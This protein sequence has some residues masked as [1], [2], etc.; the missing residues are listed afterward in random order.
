MLSLAGGLCCRGNSPVIQDRHHILMFS[1]YHQHMRTHTH[2]CVHQGTFPG[3]CVD[4]LSPHCHC[5]IRTPADNKRIFR[6]QLNPDG[7]GPAFRLTVYRFLGRRRAR[8]YT[9]T[10]HNLISQPLIQYILLF[11]PLRGWRAW[12]KG[13]TLA[14]CGNSKMFVL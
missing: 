8:K 11:H 9:E 6:N 12:I 4:P 10:Q 5:Y 14:N 7:A 1:S 3:G 13:L 2:T